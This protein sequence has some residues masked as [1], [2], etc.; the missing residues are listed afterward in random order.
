MKKIEEMSEDELPEFIEKK[1]IEYINTRNDQP[2]DGGRRDNYKL[3]LM[4]NQSL[5]EAL[6]AYVRYN[7]YHSKKEAIS[8][9]IRL[10]VFEGKKDPDTITPERIDSK[11][12]EQIREEIAKGVDSFK[13]Q[14]SNIGLA[15][16]QTINAVNLIQRVDEAQEAA[17]QAY[18]ARQVIFN[19][20]RETNM[21][22]R[23]L[24]SLARRGKLSK[25]ELKHDLSTTWF[26][27]SDLI[28]QSMPLREWSDE[29]FEKSLKH[30]EQFS[31]IQLDTLFPDTPDQILLVS[32][33]LQLQEHEE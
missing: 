21:R 32:L 8:H 5:G 24:I 17:N 1:Y 10:K 3:Y 25:E 9:F 18:Q 22:E 31:V 6:E 29:L 20:L 19:E 26:S 33:H 2:V 16:S 30:L 28:S 12:I 27:D 4:I 14:L 23:I 11:L 15:A 13:D 7:K